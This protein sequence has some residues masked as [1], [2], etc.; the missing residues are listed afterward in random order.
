MSAPPAPQ[1]RPREPRP[2]SSTQPPRDVI[3]TLS[4]ACLADPD[5][6]WTGLGRAAQA[7]CGVEAAGIAH[8]STAPDY[9]LLASRVGRRAREV[10]WNDGGQPGWC[11]AIRVGDDPDARYL[12]TRGSESPA[13]CARATLRA[14]ATFATLLRA[15]D[16]RR[17]AAELLLAESRHR[18]V[19]DLQLV[20]GLLSWQA[21]AAGDA[22][23]AAALD[24]VSDRV[25]ALASVRAAPAGDLAAALRDLLLAVGAQVHDRG[26]LLSLAILGSDRPIDG[27]CVAAL[28]I[29]VNELVTNAIKHAFEPGKGGRI[30]VTLSF[31]E[32]AVTVSVVDDGWRPPD[33]AASGSGQQLLRRLIDGLGGRFVH[34][35]QTKHFLIELPA[36]HGSGRDRQGESSA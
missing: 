18:A 1:L 29:G 19:N 26:I 25:G 10:V 14:V 6:I 7:L 30:E 16:R 36:R 22:R 33:A 3:A 8:A 11:A 20:R 23:T 9:A 21:R 35:P 2:A 31:G 17:E 34:L 15:V 4:A 5:D 27:R 28:L 13:P 24:D 12:W 32:A